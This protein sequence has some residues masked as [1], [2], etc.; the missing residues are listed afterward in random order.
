[1]LEIFTIFIKRSFIIVASCCKDCACSAKVCPTMVLQTLKS[2]DMCSEK[3]RH[4][5]WK[6]IL[7]FCVLTVHV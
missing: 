2:G 1:M 4:I 3:E 6:E 5:A 7:Y